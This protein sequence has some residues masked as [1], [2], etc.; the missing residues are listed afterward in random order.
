MDVK[1]TF[2]NG[3]LDEKFDEVVLSSGYLLNKA[4]KCAYIKFDESGK[5]FIICLYVDDMLIFGTDQ[6]QVDL[7]K[8]LLSS[9]FS[10]KDMRE[11]DVILGKLSRYTSNP[12]TEHWQAIQKD[13]LMQAGS[14]NTEDTSSS[15][16]WVFLFGVAA[17]KE[18]VSLT[19][20]EAGVLHVNWISFGHCV[21]RRG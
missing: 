4:D 14:A 20:S 9:R 16:G 2:L 6:D 21:S 12:S 17:G 1:T 5:G 18:A 19:F 13:T 7:T 10:M 15:S 11:A 3:E 8:K